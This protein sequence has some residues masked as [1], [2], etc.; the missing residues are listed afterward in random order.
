LNLSEVEGRE[1][2]IHLSMGDIQFSVT[3][4]TSEQYRTTFTTNNLDI[5]ADIDFDFYLED[6][7]PIKITL[8]LLDATLSGEIH[9]DKSN[10]GITS[11]LGTIS[12]EMDT[13]SLLENFN[14]ELPTIILRFIPSIPITLKLQMDFDVP[15]LLIQYPLH[16]GNE[17]ILPQVT[18]N[19]DGTLE[20]KYFRLINILNKIAGKIGKAF[21]PPELAQH[22]PVIDISEILEDFNIPSE[23]DIPEVTNIFREKPF[24]CSGQQLITVDGGT[25]NTY[26]ITIAHSAAEMYYSPELENVVKIQGNFNDF[27][28]IIDDITLELINFEQ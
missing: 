2:N 27:I 6:K 24:I 22:L 10:M 7:N 28:P 16:E 14:L 20:S 18:I 4:V 12:G 5:L 19:I 9:F 25:F 17:W 3:E 8:E 13:Q 1:M 21:I 15:Y 26:Y 11:V 23:N